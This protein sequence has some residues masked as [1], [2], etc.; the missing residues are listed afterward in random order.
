MVVC[1][2]CLCS[3]RAGL[4]VSEF[5]TFKQVLQDLNI[6]KKQSSYTANQNTVNTLFQS[7]LSRLHALFRLDSSTHTA[8]PNTVCSH[9]V[10]IQLAMDLVPFIPNQHKTTYMDTLQLTTR[11]NNN[12][13][14]SNSNS[15]HN[16]N[17]NSH[18]TTSHLSTINTVLI[19]RK[20][21]EHVAITVDTD[22]NMN[23]KSEC[24]SGSGSMCVDSASE[25]VCK[26]EST[27]DACH[28]VPNKKVKTH[29]PVSI[30]HHSLA[31]T[32]T[33]THAHAPVL[34][35]QQ[36]VSRVRL[37]LTDLNTPHT[38]NHSNNNNN[39]PYSRF[40]AL[41][42]QL[43]TLHT[44]HK[45]HITLSQDTK[46]ALSTQDMEHNKENITVNHHNNTPHS[47]DS[48]AHP[49][50][51]TRQAQQ[52]CT[53]IVQLFQ[54]GQSSAKS[55]S[56]STH[57]LSHTHADYTLLMNQY[58]KHCPALFRP[59]YQHA[60]SLLDNEHN[61]VHTHFAVDTDLTHTSIS[62]NTSH[63][64]IKFTTGTTPTS[65]HIQPQH[66]DLVMG[67]HKHH[68]HSNPSLSPS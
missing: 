58:T 39:N 12:N 11:A 14:N 3:V 6:V 47:T 25:S 59:L 1:V 18:N 46:P 54:H 23:V 50:D 9:C 55:H 66:Y 62:H 34:T 45:Q 49:D 20:Q 4:S 31:H 64:P 15:S 63:R 29:D 53:H 7:I 48:T 28:C 5:T 22:S 32:Q 27:G 43:E 67:Q 2:Y 57:S 17:N 10:R 42:L 19:K 61:K 13:N 26:T 38:H 36:F 35:Q 30:T 52:L 16:S 37:L 65:A 56:Y 41:V 51:C 21:R 68:T 33:P 8:I 44:Q 40:K 24:G 60:L